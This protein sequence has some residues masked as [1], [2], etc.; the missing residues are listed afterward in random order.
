MADHQNDTLRIVLVGR[1]GSG[2]SASANT[3]L[4]EKKFES[5]ISAQSFTRT[6]QRA[7]R[8]WKGRQLLVV[9]TP[10]LFD[11][12]ESLNTMCEEISRCVVYS[13]PGPHAIIVVMQLDCYTTKDQNTVALIKTVFGPEVTKNMIVLFT[14]KEELEGCSLDSFLESADV[15]LRSIIKE[16]GNRYFAISNKADK[17]EKEVQVQMLV[18]LIDKMVENNGGAYFSHRIYENMEEKLQKR[19]EILKKIYAEERD[20]KIRLIEKECVTKLEK[21]KEEQIKLIMKRYEEKIRNI[22]AEA[23]KNIFKDVLDVIWKTISRVW[24]TFWK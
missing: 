5:R 14:R 3:I 10:G 23:E 17:V 22:M 24:H 11:T 15:N 6:C 19:G 1:T 20:N 8:A 9:D 16:C 12:K 2:K 21:E 4:G 13:C 7:T 18:E